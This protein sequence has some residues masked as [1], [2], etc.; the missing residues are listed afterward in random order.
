MPYTAAQLITYFTNADDGVA[1]SA[2]ETVLLSAYAAQ[3]AAGAIS[4]NQALHYATQAALLG[5]TGQ[6]GTIDVAAATYQFFTGSGLSQVGLNYLV[7]PVSQ[8][9]VN[10]TNLNSTYYSQF[11]TENRF[12]NMSLALALAPGANLTN[13]TNTYGSLTLNQT[14]ATAYEAIIGQAYVGAATEAAGIAYMQ[15]AAVESYFLATAQ[16]RAPVGSDLSL[17][18]KAVAIGFILDVAVVNNVGAYAVALDHYTAALANGTASAAAQNLL[19]Y[20]GQSSGAGF[21]TGVG[22]ALPSVTD[23]GNSIAEGATVTFTFTDANLTP[24]MTETWT[25]TG[26]GVSEVVGPTSGTLTVGAGGVAQVVVNTTA[27]VINHAGTAPLTLSV[28]SIPSA[29]DTVTINNNATITTSAPGAAVNEGSPVTFTV[30]A[31]SNVPVGTVETWTLT[32]ATSEVSGALTGTVTVNPGGTVTVTIPTLVNVINSPGTASLTLSLNGLAG[33]SSTATINNNAT[34]S[35]SDAIPGHAVNEGQSITF[36]INASSNVAIGT[37]VAYTLSGSAVG[38]VTSP[39]TGIATIGAGG[40][41]NVT[42]NTSATDFSNVDKS[43]TLTLNGIGPGAIDT[44]TIHENAIPSLVLTTG[45]DTLTGSPAATAGLPNVFLATQATLGQNDVLTGAGAGNVLS[46][47]TTGGI[48][49]VN[50][51]GFTTTGI[52]TQIVNASTTT[53]IDE[54]SVSGLTLFDDANSTANVTLNAVLGGGTHGLTN[55]KFDTPTDTTGPVNLT[56]NYVAA[57]TSGLGPNTQNVELNNVIGLLSNLPDSNLF[58]GGVGSFAI[59]L[60]PGTNGLTSLNGGLGSS[61]LTSVAFSGTA[62]SPFILGNRAAGPASLTFTGA[63]TLSSA[64]TL[65]LTALSGVFYDLGNTGGDIVSNGGL[66]IRGGAGGMNS[67]YTPSIIGGTLKTGGAI[68]VAGNTSILIDGGSFL[69]QQVTT[70]AN[71]SVSIEGWNTTTGGFLSNGTQSTNV[72]AGGSGSINIGDTSGFSG[73]LG[74][75]NTAD[76]PNNTGLVVGSTLTT[77]SGAIN[78]GTATAAGSVTGGVNVD[79]VTSTGAVNV[80]LASGAN[81]VLVNRGTGS[82]TFGQKTTVNVSGGTNQIDFT[83][84][85][86]G[87]EQYSNGFYTEYDTVSAVSAAAGANTTLI[88][89]AS[90][91]GGLATNVPTVDFYAGSMTS[92]GLINTQWLN[93]AS[94]TSTMVYN[95]GTAG[96]TSLRYLTDQNTINLVTGADN[97]QTVQLGNWYFTNATETLNAFSGINSLTVDTTLDQSF[98]NNYIG[99]LNFGQHNNVALTLVD[100]AQLNT[101]NFTGAGN[102]TVQNASTGSASVSTI[103]GDSNYSFYL[104][105]MTGSNVSGTYTGA[106]LAGVGFYGAAGGSNSNANANLLSSS[107]GVINTSFLNSGGGGQTFAAVGGGSWTITTGNGSS[108]I[109]VN[110]TGAASDVVTTGSG[111]DV[112]Y[113]GAVSG[114]GGTV[115]IHTDGG[116]DTIV[117]DLNA[118]QANWASDT[119]AG[120]SGY[121]M[122]E[123]MGQGGYGSVGGG[124]TIGDS[125]FAGMSGINEIQLS[126]G[127]NNSLTLAG[128]AATESAGV[129]GLTIDTGGNGVNGSTKIDASALAFNAG[130]VVNLSNANENGSWSGIAGDRGGDSITVGVNATSLTVNSTVAAF[131]TSI[132]GGTTAAAGGSEGIFASNN[133]ANDTLNLYGDSGIAT[134]LGNVTGVQNINGWSYNTSNVG[135]F[136]ATATAPT[137]GEIITLN[138]GGVETVWGENITSTGLVETALG[139]NYQFNTYANATL[140]GA[141]H[142]GNILTSQAGGSGMSNYIYSPGGFAATETGANGGAAVQGGYYA[143]YDG[144]TFI[145][146]NIF[147]ESAAQLST[148]GTSNVPTTEVTITN[149]NT[150]TDKIAI[151]AAY[152]P[153]AG[154][155]YAGSATT[156]L[157][158]QA[159]LNNTPAPGSAYQAVY[160]ADNHTLWISRDGALDLSASQIVLS[161]GTGNGSTFSAANFVTTL[162]GGIGLGYTG[163]AG[164]LAGSNSN[165]VGIVYGAET[166]LNAVTMTIPL[167]TSIGGN[168]ASLPGGTPGTTFQGQGGTVLANPTGFG[169]TYDFSQ[170]SSAVTFTTPD[171]NS[172]VTDANAMGAGTVT[173]TAFNDSFNVHGQDLINGM[174]VLG[175]GGVDTLTVDPAGPLSITLS[176]TAPGV[177]TGEVQGITNLILVDTAGSTISFSGASTGIKNITGDTGPDTINTTGMVAGGLIDLTQGGG[178]TVNMGGNNLAGT[179]INFASSGANLLNFGAGTLTSTVNGGAGASNTTLEVATADISTAALSNINTLLIASGSTVTL[180]G[181]EWNQMGQIKTGTQATAGGAVT[182]GSGAATITF[183]GSET[184][185]ASANLNGG[186]TYNLTSGVNQLTLVDNSGGFGIFTGTVNGGIG[187]DTVVLGGL[188][189]GSFLGSATIDLGAGANVLQVSTGAALAA[190]GILGW[191]PTFGD[192]GGTTELVITGTGASVTMNASEYALFE[193]APVTAVATAHAAASHMS[194][195]TTDTITF[196]NAVTGITLDAAVGTYHLANAPNSVT[197]GSDSQNVTGGTGADTINVGTYAITGALHFAGNNGNVL[198]AGNGA[199]LSGASALDTTGKVILHFNDASGDTVTMTSGQEVLFNTGGVMTGGGTSTT[200]DITDNGSTVVLGANE[201]AANTVHL[202]ASSTT[203]SITLGSLNGAVAGWNGTLQLGTTN[204]DTI[205]LS[206]GSPGLPGGNPV[207]LSHYVTISGFSGG[208][209]ATT[210]VIH[211]ASVDGVTTIAGEAYFSAA[212]AAQLA[213]VNDI[214]THDGVLTVAANDASL[215]TGIGTGGG[216]MNTF[217]QTTAGIA[218]GASST[219]VFAITDS[220]GATGIYDIHTSAG[221]VVDGVQLMGLLTGV[222]TD[223]LYAHNF[224]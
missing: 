123:V 165:T 223:A 99:V 147:A 215:G 6:Q 86:V 24:G 133:A 40:T 28:A 96:N 141:K 15:S 17:A 125:G 153:V 42:V 204:T 85:A 131:N 76:G 55:L 191:N 179:T 39:L 51:T 107:G 149:F 41:V 95:V 120:G 172:G 152:L 136:F 89:N 104:Q 209:G 80:N 214:A 197:L 60:D 207:D 213:Q 221:S 160:E 132:D 129:G 142:T 5:N 8:G 170:L 48:F 158:A 75:R 69:G 53:T 118:T 155:V 82:S 45:T 119:L 79:L 187:N 93:Q 74:G 27:N 29:A 36:T 203:V 193:L 63:S 2:A 13:F 62:A 124:M 171:F 23:N 181:G 145:F 211:L 201:A 66:T 138:S 16:A 159:L 52:P 68:A 176:G 64:N 182:A 105:G 210:D 114:G 157:Q 148:L 180:T 168:T 188:A 57:V 26:A 205:S 77:G 178:D 49:G 65:D 116:N 88:L 21:F 189:L 101:L 140:I 18:T 139:G 100:G 10:P 81:T 156:Y 134:I 111:N 212:G 183:T 177:G 196:T 14:I 175:G 128:S 194:A 206:N 112:V 83:Q 151:N 54:S 110:P 146:N 61:I 43:L 19:T 208:L 217:I 154:I 90:H 162:G 173:G 11:N 109:V 47:T 121:N 106:Y 218:L 174:V 67:Q 32:G 166:G 220:A 73:G 7:L 84:G 58:V 102:I 198:D 35:V 12:Y 22:M 186:S 161:F 184:V 192:T 115:N 31:S 122:I 150:N 25:L 216:T 190:S 219:Y 126:R 202:G 185:T 144:T 163:A 33:S 44:V 130:L 127:V 137:S 169:S 34:I 199:D 37:A 59:T 108:M 103:T 72:T 1:P 117:F 167:Y 4:D 71:G 143:N 30:A 70:S 3:N 87:F 135:V 200:I 20:Y 56:V 195:S 78:I 94:L 97:G 9:G 113:V 91:L 98:N 50:L 46:V 224:I 38:Q 222:N 92:A 164:S